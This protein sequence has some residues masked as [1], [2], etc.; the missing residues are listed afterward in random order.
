MVVSQSS[1]TE[2]TLY[3]NVAATKS[4]GQATVD[5]D[6]G[7]AKYSSSVTETENSESAS[8]TYA[9]VDKSKKSTGSRNRQDAGVGD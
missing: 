7:Q 3:A 6:K 1:G 4:N 2:E 5:P 9:Q 8:R